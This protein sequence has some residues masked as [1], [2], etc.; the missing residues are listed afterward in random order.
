MATYEQYVVHDIMWLDLI[1]SY[2]EI[3]ICLFIYYEVL[4]SE[5]VSK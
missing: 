1:V 4:V 5:K 2:S 3:G